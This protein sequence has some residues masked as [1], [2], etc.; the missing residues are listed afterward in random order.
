M[1]DDLPEVKGIGE[2]GGGIVEADFAN[3]LR[4][5][6]FPY[7]HGFGYQ[8]EGLERFVLLDPHG[9]PICEVNCRLYRCGPMPDENK[10]KR[11]KQKK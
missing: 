4:A 1:T 7:S 2:K 8:I 9:E 11:E 3:G 10:K 6:F 5:R